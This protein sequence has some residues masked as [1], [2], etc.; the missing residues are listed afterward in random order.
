M[1]N[2]FTFNL[3]KLL[4]LNAIILCE[5]GEDIINF[6]ITDFLVLPLVIG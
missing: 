3:T 6:N 2:I 4:K 1:N 5:L